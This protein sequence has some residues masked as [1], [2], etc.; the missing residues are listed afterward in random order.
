MQK[1]NAII[2]VNWCAVALL[3]PSVQ[4]QAA[5]IKEQKEKIVDLN[6]EIVDVYLNQVDIADLVEK[7]E[8]SEVGTEGFNKVKE[9]LI[10]HKN[11]I[12]TVR[13]EE[14]NTE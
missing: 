5:K 4:A 7:L 11:T 8:Q 6:T 1:A 9:E 10:K 12:R 13:N 3:H 2:Q 14:D